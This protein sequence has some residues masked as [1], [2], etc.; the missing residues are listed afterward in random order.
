MADHAGLA[1]AARGDARVSGRCEKM[2]TGAFAVALQLADHQLAGIDRAGAREQ[3][4]GL[5]GLAAKRHRAV[6]DHRDIEP[7]GVDAVDDQAAGSAQ[8][9]GDTAPAQRVDFKRPAPASIAEPSLAALTRT[10]TGPA[11][12]PFFQSPPKRPTLLPKWTSPASTPRRSPQ[13]PQP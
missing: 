2:V 4:T 3:H 13:P 9:N 5:F 12:P 6:A 1:D 11:P 10:T 8:A 7:V